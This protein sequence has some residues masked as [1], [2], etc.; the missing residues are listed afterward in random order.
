VCKP[1]VGG[2][3]PV[4]TD[5]PTVLVCHEGPSESAVVG[6][7]IGEDGDLEVRDFAVSLTRG[8]IFSG[9]V[10]SPVG[11]HDK[12]G[13]GTRCVNP[14]VAPWSA[15]VPNFVLIDTDRRFASYHRWDGFVE[16]VRI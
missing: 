3:L 7:G 15:P 11:W 9:H 5:E 16:M 1:W 10:H 4:V 6:R 13:A 2:V 12:V 8:L 14:G